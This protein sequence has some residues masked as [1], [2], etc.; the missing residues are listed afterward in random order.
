MHH[1]RLLVFLP[2]WFLNSQML[3]LKYCSVMRLGRLGTACLVQF[4][5]HGCGVELIT[6]LSPWRTVT[7]V[8]V[9]SLLL[10]IP[11]HPHTHT[12][13]TVRREKD[14]Q[15]SMGT[16]SMFTHR[17]HQIFYEDPYKPKAL[18][19]F[20]HFTAEATENR[21]GKWLPT[22]SGR[23]ESELSCAPGHLVVSPFFSKV[24][25]HFPE[26]KHSHTH[27]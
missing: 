27:H 14:K 26:W 7:C 5:G 3:F 23:N 1:T 25:G 8:I 19:Q 16:K 13:L 12:R 22:V 21:E 2:W 17:Q 4:E 9:P 6:P 24:F 20:S 11:P 10:H 15:R 18:G